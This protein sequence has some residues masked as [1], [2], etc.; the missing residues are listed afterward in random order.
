MGLLIKAERPRIPKGHSSQFTQCK[1]GSQ[2][3][4]VSPCVYLALGLG[5][6]CGPEWTSL[7]SR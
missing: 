5:P 7:E 4:T 2:W 6:Q 1:V 3:G